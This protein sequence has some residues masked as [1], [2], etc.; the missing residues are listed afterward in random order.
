MTLRDLYLRV[1]AA[2]AGAHPT[3]KADVDAAFADHEAANAPAADPVPATA[4]TL[5][6]VPAVDLGDAPAPDGE[7]A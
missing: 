4:P 2:I 6:I 1:A 7:G 3:V 5:T